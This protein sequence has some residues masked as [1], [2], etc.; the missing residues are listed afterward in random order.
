MK[1]SIIRIISA[2]SGISSATST[3]HR[4][5]LRRSPRTARYSSTIASRFGKRQP[6]EERAAVADAA[7]ACFERAA[8]QLH[9]TPGERQADAEPAATR[10]NLVGL[11]EHVENA[12][13]LGGIDADAESL[14][15]TVA[16][17]RSTADMKAD[18]PAA[19]GIFRGVVEEVADRLR[20]RV[21]SASTQTDSSGSL[22]STT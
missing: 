21:E 9:Q 7:A 20:S 17:P 1:S 19:I 10:S 3:R 18:T 6:G 15:A 14:I 4:T 2:A 12:R 22:I 8:V 5:D 11:H 16:G 13:Q